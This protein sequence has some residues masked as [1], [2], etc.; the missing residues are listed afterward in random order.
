[1]PHSPEHS[2]SINS[3]LDNHG[4]IPLAQ[5]FDHPNRLNHVMMGIN[6]PRTVWPHKSAV[7]TF[8][9]P[10]Y[11]LFNIFFRPH[12]FGKSCRFYNDNLNPLL[13]ALLKSLQSLSRRTKMTAKSI[14]SII[15][16]TFENAGIPW[17]VFALTLIG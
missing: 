6:D 13:T 11:F 15:S 2:G 9:H 3:R 10:L 5:V 16:L 7:I 4:D 14:G 8:C 1:M 17:I 12:G